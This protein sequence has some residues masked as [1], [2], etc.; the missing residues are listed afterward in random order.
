LLIKRAS[1]S[2]DD[3]TQAKI[4]ISATLRKARVSAGGPIP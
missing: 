4:L 3:W 2:G 1:D